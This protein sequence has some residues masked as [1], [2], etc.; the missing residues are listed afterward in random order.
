MRAAE[1]PCLYL[2][3]LAA[4][5]LASGD[6]GFSFAKGRHCALAPVSDSEGACFVPRIPSFVPYRQIARM[7]EKQGTKVKQP[8]R[9]I[10][11]TCSQNWLSG[12]NS[13]RHNTSRIRHSIQVV[14]RTPHSPFGH[15]SL[16]FTPQL[17]RMAAIWSSS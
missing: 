17:A 12:L 4:A 8:V 15:P 13:P 14:N 6:A 9:S 7:A 3:P 11:H 1:V 10:H 16:T 2:D 5:V